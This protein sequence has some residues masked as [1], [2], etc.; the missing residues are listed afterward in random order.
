MDPRL[1]AVESCRKGAA[2]IVVMMMVV[3]RRQSLGLSL[4]T[5]SHSEGLDPPQ[6][7]GATSIPD[8]NQ[9]GRI[10]FKGETR[11]QDSRTN[12]TLINDRLEE[13]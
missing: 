10:K 7:I 1:S 2:A 13:R 6:F 9:D 8:Y 12:T 5:P 4:R 11:R 3:V